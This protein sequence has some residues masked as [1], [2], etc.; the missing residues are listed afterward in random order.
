MQWRN[1]GRWGPLDIFGGGGGGGGG[2]RHWLYEL[3]ES[4]R[5]LDLFS[6]ELVDYFE[7]C[8]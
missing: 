4:G 2:C 5:G 1:G 6:S 3:F 7:H 8:V